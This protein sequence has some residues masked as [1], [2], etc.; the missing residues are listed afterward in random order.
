MSNTST[1]NTEELLDLYAELVL[2]VLWS[3]ENTALFKND[4]QAYEKVRSNVENAFTKR[5]GFTGEQIET[6]L[7]SRF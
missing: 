4:P 5:T 1:H 2:E 7:V 6:I 3:D